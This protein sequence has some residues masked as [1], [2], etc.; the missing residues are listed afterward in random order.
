MEERFDSKTLKLKQA[1]ARHA[2]ARTRARTFT[3][4]YSHT[5]TQAQKGRPMDE[6][7]EQGLTDRLFDVGSLNVSVFGICNI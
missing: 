3:Q 5:F 2:R 6:E 4:S 1:V 7:R